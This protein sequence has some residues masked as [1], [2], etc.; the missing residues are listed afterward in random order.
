[1]WEYTDTVREHF[2][3]PRN[4]GEMQNANAIGDVGSLSCGDAL[5]LFLK[6][7]EKGIIEDASFQTF[8]CA[9]AIASSSALTEMVKGKHVDEAAKITNKE[10][11]AYL[12]GL[13]EAKMHCSVMGEEALDAALRSWRGESAKP[14]CHEGTVICTCFGITDLQIRRIAQESNLTTVEDIT[15]YT[16]AGGGCGRCVD[17][18]QQILDEEQ[19]KPRL[20]ELNI[21]P[22]TMLTNIQRMQKIM[23]VLEDEIKP[24]LAVDGGD[25]ELID[26]NGQ[27]VLVQFLGKCASCRSRQNTIREMVEKILR[28]QVESDLHVEEVSA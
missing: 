20:K 6:I 15:H 19:G 12:G 13:P 8:G 3:N 16:K 17:A 2:L 7:S 25:I 22:K 18:I 14:H 28:E 11:A 27:E 26:V 1:M 24:R 5:K 21:K 4:A 9:S 23:H 10:I